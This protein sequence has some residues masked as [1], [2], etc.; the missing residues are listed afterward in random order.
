MI[1]TLIYGTLRAILDDTQCF[2]LPSSW[3]AIEAV[4]MVPGNTPHPLPR[5]YKLTN[6][7]GLIFFPAIPN[8]TPDGIQ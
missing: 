3:F 5:T 7:R 4:Y 6:S 1:P 2:A 8:R